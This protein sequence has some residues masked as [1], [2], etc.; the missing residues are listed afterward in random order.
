MACARGGSGRAGRRAWVVGAAGVVGARWLRPYGEEWLGAFIRGG[1][2]GWEGV[3]RTASGGG[4]GER[5]PY[6]RDELPR[7]WELVTRRGVR[8]G[9][10]NANACDGAHRMVGERKGGARGMA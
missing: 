5:W 1:P 3:G 9:G 7:G 2:K 6:V 10:E 8:E 4:L